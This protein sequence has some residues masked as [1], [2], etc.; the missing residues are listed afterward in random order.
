M[1]LHNV[2]LSRSPKLPYIQCML[3]NI[4]GQAHHNRL[5]SCNSFMCLEGRPHARCVAVVL[6]LQAL[7]RLSSS[8]PSSSSSSVQ[9]LNCD[10]TQGCLE[11]RVRLQLQSMFTGCGASCIMVPDKAASVGILPQ[12]GCP[13][14]LPSHR[15]RAAGTVTVT[16]AVHGNS[17]LLSLQACSCQLNHQGVC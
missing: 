7:T 9:S 12:A 2:R 10:C 13:L 5:L 1:A 16:T 4:S 11:L 15:G 8:F 14:G 6:L 17:G 3:L